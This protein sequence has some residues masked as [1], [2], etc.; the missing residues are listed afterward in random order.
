MELCYLA[1]V[2]G[3]MIWDVLAQLLPRNKGKAPSATADNLVLHF[4]CALKKWNLE[5]EG[6]ASNQ[7]IRWFGQRG[8]SN[9]DRGDSQEGKETR[10]WTSFLG[11]DIREKD[12]FSYG[13]SG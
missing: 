7:L 3:E 8:E 5:S 13:V 12:V 1:R 10:V 9:L 6:E 4:D 11:S 2:P